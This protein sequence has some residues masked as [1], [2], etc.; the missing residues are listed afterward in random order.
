VSCSGCLVGMPRGTGLHTFEDG[1]R[2]KHVV[3][4]F[5]A[6]R[7]EDV[8]TCKACGWA[9]LSIEPMVVHSAGDVL[10]AWTDAPCSDGISLAV[11][12]RESGV[13]YSESELRGL[14]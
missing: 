2:F 11:Y 7:A 5:V 12:D 3:S 1:C 13:L 8:G 14:L 6:V 9:W 4:R 10:Q